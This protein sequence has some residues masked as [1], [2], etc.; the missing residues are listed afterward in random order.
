MYKL[1]VSDMD[2]TLLNEGH[3]V[4]LETE[5]AL[6]AAKARGVKVVLSTGRPYAGLGQ[7]KERLAGL[8]DYTASYNGALVEDVATGK[9]YKNNFLDYGALEYLYELSLA[10][11]VGMHFCDEANIYTPNRSVRPATMMDALLNDTPLH[12]RDVDE[13][14]RDARFPKILFAGDKAELDRVTGELPD[15]VYERFTVVRSADVFLEF[16]HLETSKGTAL[17]QILAFEGLDAAQA[18]AFGDNEND[19]SML[20][21]AGMGVAMENATDQVKAVADHVTGTNVAHGVAE[22]IERFVLKKETI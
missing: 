5:E 18:I 8:V 19:I 4:S 16:I 10:L 1:I 22:A 20:E 21:L 2:G 14:A 7:Y 17:E 13:I 6:R 15:E 3:E 9:L 12:V 11:N